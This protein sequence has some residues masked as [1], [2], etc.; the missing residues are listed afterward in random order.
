[1]KIILTTLPRYLSRPL[2]RFKNAKNKKNSLKSFPF[3]FSPKIKLEFLN[4]KKN[5]YF[6]DFFVLL[7]FEF[8][9][10]IF[11]IRRNSWIILPLL[12][13]T[14]SLK[15]KIETTFKHQ[16]HR[17]WSKVCKLNFVLLWTYVTFW[18]L[19]FKWPKFKKKRYFWVKISFLE[20]I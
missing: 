12:R 11:E 16:K 17:Y 4:T 5:S 14:I 8:E 9:K 7:L 15:F 13:P 2:K 3:F 19:N 20:H 10:G 6:A 1:M 18:Y